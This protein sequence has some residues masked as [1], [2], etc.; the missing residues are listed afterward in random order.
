MGIKKYIGFSILIIL[1]IGA[2]IYTM[3]SGIY[4]V[5]LLGISLELPIAVWVIVPMTIL[6]IASVLHLMFYGSINYCKQRAVCKDES[7]IVEIIKSL[8]LQKTNSKKFKT[9]GYK[10]AASI[11]SQFDVDVKED[12][13][14]SG[15]EELNK[16]VGQVKDIKAGKFINDKTLKLNPDTALFKQNMINKV[17]E[18]IDFA[19]D[20]LKRVDQYSDEV[21]RVSFLN[22]LENKSMTT[23]K[24]VYGNVPLDKETAFKLFIKDVENTDFGLSKDEILKLTKSLSYS[25]EEYLHLAKIYKDGLSPDKLLELFEKLSEDDEAATDAYFYVLVE[26]EMIDKTRELL[27]GYNDNE[28][29]SFRALLDLKDA[30]KHYSYNDITTI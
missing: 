5:T 24:K 25:K 4:K 17:T 12:S 22:V 23:I 8:V 18:Q 11:L 10:N 3:E 9:K 21:V 16:I 6:F 15:D 13:F 7:T 14:T 30:G 28:F 27:T 1:I 2:Y 20:V 26:L 19:L 29:L